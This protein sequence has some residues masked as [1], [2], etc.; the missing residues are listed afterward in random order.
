MC[1]RKAV[2]WYLS[3]FTTEKSPI[4]GFMKGDGYLQGAAK[5]PPDSASNFLHM[6]SF[7]VDGASNQKPIKLSDD[8]DKLKQTAEYQ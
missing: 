3:H 8:A 6:Y 2:S 4:A 1:Y 5:V 7:A